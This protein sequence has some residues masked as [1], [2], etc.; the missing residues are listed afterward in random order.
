MA[1]GKLFWFDRDAEAKNLG[2]GRLNPPSGR[3]WERGV[4]AR[5]LAEKKN[6]R[7]P[8]LVNGMRGAT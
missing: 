2:T 4:L 8:A 7:D 6:A 1:A 3:N 5:T